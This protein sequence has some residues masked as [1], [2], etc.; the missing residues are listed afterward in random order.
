M[1]KYQ[2]VQTEFWHDL[3]V[4]KWTP[5]VK[6]VFLYLLTNPRAHQC[7]VQENN[8]ESIAMQTGLQEPEVVEALNFLE[9][10]RKIKVSATTHEIAICNW[11]KHNMTKSPKVRTCIA[12]GLKSVKNRE[13]IKHLRD[14]QAILPET[15]LPNS[16]STS[17]P[18]PH[19]EQLS[20]SAEERARGL[21]A[22]KTAKERINGVHRFPATAQ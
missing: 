11:L 21:E 6:L 18:K 1:A 7:G 4:A 15:P 10:V 12:N 13:L 16:L 3:H 20:E 19:H 5:V 2:Y 14:V 17:T 9:K 22:L 8:A